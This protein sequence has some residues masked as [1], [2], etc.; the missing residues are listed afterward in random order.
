MEK[1]QLQQQNNVLLTLTKEEKKEKSKRKSLQRIGETRVMNC[2]QMAYIVEYNGSTDI[3]IQFKETKELVNCTYQQFKNGNIKSRLYPSVFGVGII[4]LEPIIDDDKVYRTWVDM[5]RRCYSEKL[6]EK[7]PTYKDCIVC[8]E[9]LT[10]GNFKKW[11]IENYYE[12]D[13]ERMELDKD[14]LH[15]GN[16]IYSPSTCIFVPH[17]INSL[18][19]KR[20]NDRGKYPIGVHEVRGKFVANCSG[21]TRESKE[22]IGTYNTPEDAFYKGYKPHKEKFIKDKANEYKEKIPTNLY[23]A[24]I[25]YQVS[26]TD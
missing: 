5:L 26:I 9:W 18:M 8:D 15:K 19:T 1:L 11:Y 14:I 10:Y 16:K 23:I 13:E 24:L 21:G 6:Q 12:I 7:Y 22:Y 20:K 25:N 4:G 3:W 17:S 2:G